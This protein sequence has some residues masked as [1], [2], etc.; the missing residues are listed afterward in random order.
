MAFIPISSKIFQDLLLSLISSFQLDLS[1][2]IISKLKSPESLERYFWNSS[3]LP[4]FLV[5]H[6][7]TSHLILCTLVIFSLE[8]YAFLAEIIFYNL[9]QLLHPPWNV[10]RIHWVDHDPCVHYFQV[11]FFLWFS[12]PLLSNI[13]SLR[14]GTMSFSP[15]LQQY[16]A[17]HM[18]VEVNIKQFPPSFLGRMMWSNWL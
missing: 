8:Y 14:A 9:T 6:V 13:S 4:V 5:P 7:T 17:H 15:L 10:S 1:F 12:P 11:R 16:L 3:P 18:P 2:Q